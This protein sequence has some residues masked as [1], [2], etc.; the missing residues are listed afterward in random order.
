MTSKDQFDRISASIRPPFFHLRPKVN[1]VL[2]SS[3]TS[4]TRDSIAIESATSVLLFI[5]QFMSNT[6]LRQFRDLG[7]PC[8]GWKKQMKDRVRQTP[9]K[10]PT[11]M[12][13]SQRWKEFDNHFNQIFLVD[14]PP[15]ACRS[16]TRSSFHSGFGNFLKSP[17]T[18]FSHLH[19]FIHSVSKLFQLLEAHHSLYSFIIPFLI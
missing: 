2:S 8:R 14:S 9:S 17:S 3:S 7:D 11:R 5:Q 4:L 10:P 18:I 1:D 19:S 6:W 16:K 12:L 13:C 15:V